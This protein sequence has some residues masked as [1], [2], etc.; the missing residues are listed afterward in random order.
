MQIINNTKYD[1]ILYKLKKVSKKW[2]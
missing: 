1:E 2:K